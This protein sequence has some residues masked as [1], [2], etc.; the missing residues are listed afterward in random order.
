M[1][2]SSG[3]ERLH[4]FQRAHDFLIREQNNTV[5]EQEIVDFVLSLNPSPN[6]PINVLLED[7]VE[8]VSLNTLC[9]IHLLLERHPLVMDHAEATKMGILKIFNLFSRRQSE[10]VGA[11]IMA[12]FM[13]LVSGAVRI[14]DRSGVNLK[15]E[16]NSPHL[17]V[18]GSEYSPLVRSICTLQDYL[19]SHSSVPVGSISKLLGELLSMITASLVEVDVVSSI[20]DQL[21][22]SPYF[23]LDSQ[24]GTVDVN[25]AIVILTQCLMLIDSVDDKDLKAMSKQVIGLLKKTT[26]GK[27]V[28]KLYPFAS[29]S[30]RRWQKWKR[31]EECQDVYRPPVDISVDS[32]YCHASTKKAPIE[33]ETEP[34]LPMHDIETDSHAECQLSEWALSRQKAFSITT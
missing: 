7:F 31:E 25:S 18:I 3:N 30:D 17:K 1:N 27:R 8:C 24:A 5:T 26:I 19:Y 28:A 6:Y 33:V 4:F 22:S 34:M 10:G 29:E 23:Q 11:E 21:P 16:K 20:N 13:L 14:S 15:G 12:K 32:E 9:K 2:I